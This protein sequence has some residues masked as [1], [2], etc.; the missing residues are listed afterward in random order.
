MDKTLERELIAV[1]RKHARTNPQTAT[2]P[3]G[4]AAAIMKSAW[5]TMRDVLTDAQRLEAL[6]STSP[7]LTAALL[8]DPAAPLAGDAAR[9][10]MPWPPWNVCAL[11]P[12]GRAWRS[13][14]KKSLT[15]RGR[16][17]VPPLFR[18]PALSL[19]RFPA[20]KHKTPDLSPGRAF[21]FS[22]IHTKESASTTRG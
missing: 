17:S 21:C 4:E 18:S 6:I 11:R 14:G 15:S 7:R 13:S 1:I 10:P 12:S 19:S 22:H 2:T 8:S 3:E 16:S 20:S 5:E 9:S